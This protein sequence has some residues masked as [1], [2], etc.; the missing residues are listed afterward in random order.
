MGVRFALL[1]LIYYAGAE[2]Y[3]IDIIKYDF[4]KY[5]AIII[6]VLGIIFGWLIYDFICRV[7]LNSN[8]YT[9]IGSIFFLITAMSWIYS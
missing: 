6:S 5:E 8:V 7:S 3:M 2:L 4:E 1:A 9:L